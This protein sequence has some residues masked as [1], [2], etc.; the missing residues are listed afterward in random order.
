[1]TMIHD[2]ETNKLSWEKTEKKNLHKTL[3]KWLKKST[4]FK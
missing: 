1:M 2:D 4:F 3:D